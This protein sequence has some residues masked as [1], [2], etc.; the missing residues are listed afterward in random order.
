MKALYNKNDLDMIR[1]VAERKDIDSQLDHNLR[2]YYNIARDG[3]ALKRIREAASRGDAE[4][5]FYLGVAYYRGEDVDKNKGEAVKWFCKA[6][7]QGFEPALKALPICP[8][9]HPLHTAAVSNDVETLKNLIRQGCDLEIKEGKGKTPLMCAALYGNHEVCRLL[10]EAGANVHAKD[11]ENYTPL[12][13]AALYTSNMETLEC[14]IEHGADYTARKA[15][16]DNHDDTPV[17]LAA[18]YNPNIEI[19]KYLVS[20]GVDVNEGNKCGHALAHKAAWANPNVEV[21][22]FLV[23]QGADISAGDHDNDTP[24]RLAAHMN[25]NV[26]VLKYIIS[27][28]TD[29]NVK[30]KDGETP[31]HFAAMRKSGREFLE[32][33][34]EKGADVNSIDREGKTPLDYANT[35]EKKG[36]LQKAGGKSK[37]ELFFTK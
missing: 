20:L 10:L 29:V 28:G 3:T 35:E 27:L 19:I 18:G 6:A 9:F 31:L 5:Q 23:S 4:A 22:Q 14:L 13:V 37:K 11:N 1:K 25:P 32:Y 24:L 7:E 8:P 33:L 12:H 16:T 21:L 26:E 15:P 2:H 17:Q 34:I 36:I 30:N